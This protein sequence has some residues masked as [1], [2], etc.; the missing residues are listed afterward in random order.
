MISS[1]DSCPQGRCSFKTPRVHTAAATLQPSRSREECCF[2]R[3][4]G[5]GG[6]PAVPRV[7]GFLGSYTVQPEKGGSWRCVEPLGK[8]STWSPLPRGKR[9]FPGLGPAGSSVSCRED[10]R[11]ALKPRFHGGSPRSAPSQQASEGGLCDPVASFEQQVNCWHCTCPDSEG[12]WKLR[13]NSGFPV[14][15]P[16]AP[17]Q[18]MFCSSNRDLGFSRESYSGPSCRLSRAASRGTTGVF[19]SPC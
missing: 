11:V 6:W 8:T 9:F 18:K 13:P 15:G 4:P 19:C 14:Q 16:R 7:L 17:L 3:G 1:M 12:P 10:S 2:P 5:L